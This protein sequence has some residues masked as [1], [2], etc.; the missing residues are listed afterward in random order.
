MT[1]LQPYLLLIKV[2]R[3]FDNDLKCHLEFIVFKLIVKEHVCFKNYL[4]TSN[5]QVLYNGI[6]SDFE[7][8]LG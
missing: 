8:F 6:C 3:S 1:T 7:S 4:I 5:M 2:L